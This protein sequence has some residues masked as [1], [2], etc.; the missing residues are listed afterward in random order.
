VGQGPHEALGEAR[1]EGLLLGL[2]EVLLPHQL[3][4]DLGFH[5]L[6]S[7]QKTLEGTENSREDVDRDRLCNEHAV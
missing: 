2:G 4:H 3:V 6:R 1:L 7:A 5:A